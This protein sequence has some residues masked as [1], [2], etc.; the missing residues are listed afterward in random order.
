MGGGGFGNVERAERT[1]GLAGGAI[2]FRNVRDLRNLRNLRNRILHRRRMTHPEG[3]STG[4]S[5]LASQPPEA[6]YGDRGRQSADT[7]RSTEG[8][9][10]AGSSGG[11]VG[12][13]IEGTV[14]N[15]RTVTR[16]GSAKVGCISG[17]PWTGLD[18]VPAG[19]RKRPGDKKFRYRSSVKETRR[20]A[21]RL[22]RH[23]RGGRVE[24]KRKSTT[25][26]TQHVGVPL[27][28]SPR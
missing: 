27:C 26:P 10:S 12:G 1:S 23:S 2:H 17:N 13:G 9:S 15:S 5:N 22:R 18:R 19:S 16:T 28:P 6:A 8:D 21:T 20:T 7:T 3:L 25:F 4:L 14:R 24:F 11:G